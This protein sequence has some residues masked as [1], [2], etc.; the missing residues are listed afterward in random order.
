MSDPEADL[1]HLE[2]IAK[3]RRAA[4]AQLVSAE[5]RERLSPNTLAMLK[6]ARRKGFDTIKQYQGALA[7]AKGFSS[8]NAHLNAVAKQKGFPSYDVMRRYQGSLKFYL[9]DM[10]AKGLDPET[11]E[12]R[13]PSAELSLTEM[14]QS[15]RTEDPQSK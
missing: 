12:P 4:N 3:L 8:L 15:I 6:T 2:L 5:E 1:K 11:Q 13:E 10:R 7:K 9:R 14:L